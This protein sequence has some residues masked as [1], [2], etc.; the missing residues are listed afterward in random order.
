ME[1]RITGPADT[2]GSPGSGWPGDATAA[3]QTDAKKMKENNSLVWKKI[4]FI[5]KKNKKNLTFKFDWIM[6][7]HMGINYE[8]EK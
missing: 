6:G 8:T 2:G 5:T 3:P 7:S 1:A 4:H